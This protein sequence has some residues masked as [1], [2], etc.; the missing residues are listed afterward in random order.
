MSTRYAVIPV[1]ADDEWLSRWGRTT[2]EDGWAFLGP[3]IKRDASLPWRKT[4][5]E[6]IHMGELT[7]LG[8]DPRDP[9]TALL[10][11]AKEAGGTPMTTTETKVT[12]AISVVVTTT[13]RSLIGYYGEYTHEQGWEEIRKEIA[14]L[15]SRA[16]QDIPKEYRPEIQL[17]EWDGEEPADA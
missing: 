11:A 4:E 5:G 2:T 1:T 3:V 7:F 9:P 10:D 14:T 16:Y 13:H 15:L 6:P 17:V 12:N 8:T